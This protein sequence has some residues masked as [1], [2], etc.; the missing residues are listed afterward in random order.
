MVRLRPADS[1]R[2]ADIL[3]GVSAA[4]RIEE[5][6]AMFLVLADQDLA[7]YCPIY[8]RIARSIAEDDEILSLITEHR[9]GS[10]RTAVLALGATH[11]LVLRDPDSELAA[12]YRGENNDDPWP[13]FRALIIDNAPAIAA[14]MRTRT[15]Q[16]N[17]V[18][19]SANL[20]AVYA[21][22]SRR[23]TRHGD[24]RP[25]AIIEIGPSAGLNL[26]AD[27]FHVEYFAGDTVIGS[28]GDPASRVQLRCELRGTTSFPGL[29]GMHPIADRSGLDP[30]P[31]DIT[32][33]DDA[34]WLRACVWPGVPDRPERLAAAIEI[35]RHDPPVL[36][37]G[38]A[39]QD[40]GA[41]LDSIPDHV[42]PIVTSTWV[43]AYLSRDAR[44][45]VCEIIDRFGEGRDIAFVTGEAPSSAPWVPELS[46]DQL[47]LGTDDGTPTVFGLRMWLDGRCHT[48]AAALCHPHGRWMAWFDNDSE[49]EQRHG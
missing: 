39:V 49:M 36:H 34:R 28:G 48:S 23:L 18:G 6:Q 32:D 41:L 40:L 21:S 9:P 46:T 13:L 10:T 29:A 35:A 43:L 8:E 1:P 47:A 12:I 26:L 38:D 30:A 24:D 14:T 25:L 7:G 5:L 15:T 45:Q 11:D 2:R 42:F 16:T 19:R 20:L 3:G 44:L 17:E 37:H 33:P 31:I 27:R 22:I 4:T